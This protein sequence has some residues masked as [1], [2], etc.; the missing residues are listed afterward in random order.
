MLP[1]WRKTVKSSDI[2]HGW[3]QP[4]NAQSSVVLMLL[5]QEAQPSLLQDMCILLW[6]VLVPHPPSRVALRP[7]SQDQPGPQ[8]PWRV[9]LLFYE[10][11]AGVGCGSPLAWSCYCPCLPPY[12]LVD[13]HRWLPQVPQAQPFHIEHHHHP[14]DLPAQLQEQSRHT[15]YIN[16]SCRGSWPPLSIFLIPTTW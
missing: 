1:R 11:E 7:A 16:N 13:L 15:G 5:K 10:W 4:L 2:G 14:L 3:T 6:D 9:S 8:V 12:L